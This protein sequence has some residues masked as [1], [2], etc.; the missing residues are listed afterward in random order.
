M[1]RLSIAGPACGPLQSGRVKQEESRHL[2]DS[3]LLVTAHP[4][5]GLEAAARRDRL[6]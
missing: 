4:P 6:G 3:F 2:G 5:A 1:A